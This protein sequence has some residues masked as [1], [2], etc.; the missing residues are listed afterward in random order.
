M[1]PRTVYN[2]TNNVHIVC[3]CTIVDS[4]NSI[5]VNKQSTVTAEVSLSAIAYNAQYLDIDV[6]IKGFTS[7]RGNFR[8]IDPY[9]IFETIGGKTE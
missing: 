3:D 1:T 8:L 9:T 4:C 6:K 5:N 7:N 2:T